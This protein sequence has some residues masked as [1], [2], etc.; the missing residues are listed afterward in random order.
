MLLCIGTSATF[1]SS[2]LPVCSVKN[3]YFVNTLQPLE[4]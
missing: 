2:G 1:Q 4:G 3:D